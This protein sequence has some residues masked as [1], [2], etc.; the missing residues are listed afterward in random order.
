L[1]VRRAQPGAQAGLAQKRASPLAS[2][3]GPAV[4]V[5]FTVFSFIVA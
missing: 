1:K 3:L 5:L 4:I 2:T